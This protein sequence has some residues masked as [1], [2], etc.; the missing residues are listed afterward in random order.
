MPPALLRS[1]FETLEEPGHDEHPVVVTVRNSV[2]AT[3]AEL[4]RHLRSRNHATRR[5]PSSRG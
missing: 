1:Q 4:L 5:V 3:V 2:Q